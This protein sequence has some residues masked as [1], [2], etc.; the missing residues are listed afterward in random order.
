MGRNLYC[1]LQYR[2]A[3]VLGHVFVSTAKP[4]SSIHGPT[5]ASSALS[6]EHNDM[7]ASGF[8]AECNRPGRQMERLGFG[9]PV[10][11]SF[12]TSTRRH[13]RPELG[14]G[15][16]CCRH[17]AVFFSSE[18]SSQKP[19]RDLHVIRV[20]LSPRTFLSLDRRH[21]R[22]SSESSKQAPGTD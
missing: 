6:G 20:G 3:A 11:S 17:R 4:L 8:G 13:R 10:A 21:H 1:L 15:N 22:S 18:T 16:G 9:S 19:F 14:S 7:C 5:R 12:V 2:M